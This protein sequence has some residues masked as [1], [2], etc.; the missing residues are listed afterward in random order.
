MDKLSGCIKAKTIIMKKIMTMLLLCTIAAGSYAQKNETGVPA[1]PPPPPPPS[2]LAPPPP[3]PPA[4][5][6]VALPP[7][8]PAPP[9]PP[10]PPIPDMENDLGYELSVHYNNGNNMVYVKKDGKTEKISLKEWNAKK[11]FYEKK[12]GP[13]PPPPPPPAPAKPAAPAIP[14]EQ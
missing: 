14:D 10:V 3:P 5:P 4:V 8:P 12:Y 13:L 7:V 11:A 6:Q 9:T 1:P 2:D